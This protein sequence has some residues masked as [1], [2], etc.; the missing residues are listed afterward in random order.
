MAIQRIACL[1]CGASSFSRDHNNHLVCDHCGSIF[2]TKDHVCPNCSTVNPSDARH[3]NQCGERLIRHCSVCGHD[4]PGNAEFCANC[5]NALDILEYITRRYAEE[6]KQNRE[7]L[8]ASKLADV[9]YVEEQGARLREVDEQRIASL[10][11]QQAEHQRQ[12]RV[13]FMVI[14]GGAL[15]TLLVCGVVLLLTLGPGG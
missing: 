2:R 1:N 4:N 9:A 13:I 7:A 11:Q 10:Q 3:C 14:V 5:D 6:G 12:Q 15:L 8:V